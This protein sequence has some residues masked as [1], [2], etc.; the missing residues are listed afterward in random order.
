MPATRVWPGDLIRM[1]TTCAR[2]G[3]VSI[4]EPLNAT[5]AADSGQD[6]LCQSF[7][8]PP[9]AVPRLPPWLR[10]CWA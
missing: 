4:P 3:D 10:G 2:E 8:F 9:Q 5:R 1:A 6:F 7:R